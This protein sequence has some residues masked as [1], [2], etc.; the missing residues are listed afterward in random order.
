M[1]QTGCA[2]D[3]E[4]NSG[5]LG[6]LGHIVSVCLGHGPQGF[7]RHRALAYAYPGRVTFLALSAV[8]PDR[9]WHVPTADLPFNLV[10]LFDE[11]YDRFPAHCQA[12]AVRQALEKLRPTTVVTLGYSTLAMRVAARWAR[13][14][15][16]MSLVYLSMAYGDRP[17]LFWREWAKRWVVSRLFDGAFVGGVR[18]AQYAQR[19]GIPSAR[20]VPGYEVVDNNFFAAGAAAARNRREELTQS[21]SLPSRFFLYV[22]RLDPEKN[23]AA[24]LEGYAAYRLQNSRGWGLVLVGAGS[25]ER[26][27][28]SLCKELRAPDVYWLGFRQ[29]EELPQFYGLASCLILPSLSEP[30]GLVVNEA[31]AAGLPVIVSDR[32]GC[33]PELVCD[34][35]NGF[36]WN[37]HDVPSLATLMSRMA[38]DDTDRDSM[39]EVGRRII[40]GF[41]PQTWAQNL[42]QLIRQVETSKGRLA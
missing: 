2:P 25:Q 38:S 20:I 21:L 34:G 5:D 32:C 40:A 17:R 11:P 27:L 8:A 10:T 26:Q 29:P 7:V 41:T 12:T 22:G 42:L 13:T 4:V 3:V 1:I 16:A 24:L 30:W 6:K 23:V 33:V 35:K 9:Q 14:H 36:L 37:P 19:L 31:L 39:A 18:S 15:R 28:K